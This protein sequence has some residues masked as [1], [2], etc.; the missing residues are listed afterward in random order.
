MKILASL[1]ATVLLGTLLQPAM[2]KDKPGHEVAASAEPGTGTVKEIFR[3]TGVVESIDLQK[4]HASLS[5]R[6]KLCVY[7]HT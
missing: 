5:T 3:A 2:S 6:P 1:A 7:P 4:R